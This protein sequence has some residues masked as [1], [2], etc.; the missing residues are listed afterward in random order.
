MKSIL[1]A[2]FAL[3]TLASFGQDESELDRRNG[4][5]GIHM[6]SPIDSVDGAVFRKEIDEKGAP[7][8]KLYEMSSPDYQR[9][10]DIG[11]DKVEIITYQGLVYTITVI[12]EKDP[13]LMKGLQNAL[14]PP[15]FNVRGKNYVW[16]GKYL[17]LT[18][19]DHSKNKLELLYRSNKVAALM[20]E[21]QQKKIERI[22]NDF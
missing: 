21:D 20:K 17:T 15:E 18:F 2:A 8:F 1:V 19:S 9:I 10:G 22:A 7:A 3:G 5:K 12:T 11:V 13:R 16:T 4:F 6:A 14:G